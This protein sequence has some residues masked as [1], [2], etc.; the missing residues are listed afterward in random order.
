MGY[1][2]VYVSQNLFFGP[3]TFFVVCC[4]EEV[5]EI[6]FLPYLY[7]ASTVLGKNHPGL[8]LFVVRPPSPPKWFKNVTLGFSLSRFSLNQ[9]RES[10]N[11]VTKQFRPLGHSVS[12]LQSN[13]KWSR[14]KVLT[15]LNLWLKVILKCLQAS[16]E[17]VGDSFY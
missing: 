17:P 13:L 11:S 3:L 5:W 7:M 12:G 8:S 16:N 2:S 6:P 10:A 14:S 15:W 4:K 1:V 9:Q